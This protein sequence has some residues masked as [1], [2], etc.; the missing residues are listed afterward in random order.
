M[1]YSVSSCS[2][3]SCSAPALL[4]IL[5]LIVW[6]L[7]S[8]QPIVSAAGVTGS[9]AAQQEASL[10]FAGLWG[11]FVSLCPTELLSHEPC[12]NV[13]TATKHAL[14]LKNLQ[15]SLDPIWKQSPNR[16]ISFKNVWCVDVSWTWGSQEDVVH[17]ESH[18]KI[19][20][21]LHT[22]AHRVC[23][24]RCYM[25]VWCWLDWVEPC[26]ENKS[27]HWNNSYKEIGSKFHKE[28][29]RNDNYHI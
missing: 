5:V 3:H 6:H 9:R 11:V 2:S 29:Q 18:I 14:P 4:L 28:L 16:K 22:T 7:T 15:R 26:T 12:A 24:N 25:F 10:T 13:A 8:E 1:S 17:T 21:T 19:Y 20:L 23:C 27:L